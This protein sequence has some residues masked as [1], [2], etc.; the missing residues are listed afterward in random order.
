MSC[1]KERNNRHKWKA[2]PCERTNKYIDRLTI[3]DKKE[4]I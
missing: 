3:I 4:I 2:N 1:K